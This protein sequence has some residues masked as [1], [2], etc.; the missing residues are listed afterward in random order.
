MSACTG[1]TTGSTAGTVRKALAAMDAKGTVVEEKRK[2][3]AAQQEA[4]NARSE[5][6]EMKR[7]QF[8]TF[9]ARWDLT[10]LSSVTS[11]KPFTGANPEKHAWVT[12][13]NAMADPMNKDLAMM[14]ERLAAFDEE[15]VL[16]RKDGHYLHALVN[17]GMMKRNT[18]FM[19]EWDK[20]GPQTIGLLEANQTATSL[21]AAK[22]LAG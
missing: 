9:M 2:R 14:S 1:V 16:A 21:D 10:G 7:A 11:A 5:V 3:A 20:E 13:S 19:L 6:E 15:S 18:A 8:D 22:K 12:M 17:V 4:A